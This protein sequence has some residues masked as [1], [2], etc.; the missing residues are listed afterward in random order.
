MRGNEAGKKLGLG[1]YMSYVMSEGVTS[2]LRQLAP[3]AS[4]NL[5]HSMAEAW[6]KLA[7]YEAE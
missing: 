3:Y 1:M 7:A 6:R 5:R 4:V 2:K